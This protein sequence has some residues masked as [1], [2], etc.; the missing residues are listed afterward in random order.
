[1]AHL[2]HRALLQGPGARAALGH[3][4]MKATTRT[5]TVDTL[6]I[7]NFTTVSHR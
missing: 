1:L 2:G 5:M 6:R 7:I 4:G 3:C